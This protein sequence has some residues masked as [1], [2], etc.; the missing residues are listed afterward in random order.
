MGCAGFALGLGLG[1]VAQDQGAPVPEGVGVIGLGLVEGLVLLGGFGEFLVLDELRDESEPQVASR[2]GELDGLVEPGLGLGGAAHGGEGAAQSDQGFDVVGFAFGPLLVVGDEAGL[3]VV[4][5]EDLFDFA[6]DFAMEPAIGP[7]LPE[8]GLEVVESVLGASEAN[9]QVGG[10]D[11]E[12]DLAEGIGGFFGECL[13]ARERGGGLIFLGEGGSDLFLDARVA[14]EDGFE[15]VPDF[16]SL[17]V[18]LGALIDASEGLED[19]EEIG[20]R[21]VFG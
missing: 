20:A 19:V 4:S 1:G 3:V 10:R 17:V 15:A 12:L 5:E 11:C 14:W 16:E 18:F 2:G 6:A 21:R 9:F 8:H 13:E 7:E